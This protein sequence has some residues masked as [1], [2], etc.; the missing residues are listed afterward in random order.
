MFVRVRENHGARESEGVHETESEQ[1]RER[2]GGK[3]GGGCLWGG[4]SKDKAAAESRK[5]E[6][7]LSTLETSLLTLEICL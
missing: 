2:E 3:M 4:R 7:S 5:T 6:S 1:Q